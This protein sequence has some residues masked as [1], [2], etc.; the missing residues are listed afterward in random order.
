V[1]AEAS[2]PSL[3][4]T[5]SWLLRPN[6]GR[7]TL[8]QVIWEMGISAAKKQVIQSIAVAFPCNAVPH[9]WG[10]VSWPAGAHCCQPAEIQSHIQPE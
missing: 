5:A 9:K 8:G 4:L 6:Q 3:P 1:G 10:K 2:H 7:S